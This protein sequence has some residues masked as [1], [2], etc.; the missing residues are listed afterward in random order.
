MSKNE[1]ATAKRIVVEYED[2]TV[3][4]LEKGLVF[5]FENEDSDTVNITAEMV[6]M[7]GKDLYTVV[8]AALELGM[9]LG[10]FDDKEGADDE[11]S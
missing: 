11:E 6:S 8:G 3:K 10:M 5:R 4:E 1:E 7:S 9:R 2:G